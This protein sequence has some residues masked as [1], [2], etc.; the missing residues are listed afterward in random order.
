MTEVKVYG[1]DWCPATRH[2]ID[3]LEAAGVTVQYINVEDDAEASDR[4]EE[5]E[6]PSALG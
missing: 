1:A 3:Y 2:T 5:S 6:R 4:V